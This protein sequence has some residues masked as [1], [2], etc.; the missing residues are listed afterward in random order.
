MADWV[1]EGVGGNKN[2]AMNVDHPTLD[3]L[4]YPSLSKEGLRVRMQNN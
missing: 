4:G 3:R 2:I 1:V